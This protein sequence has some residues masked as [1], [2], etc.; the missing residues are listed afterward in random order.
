MLLPALSWKGKRRVRKSSTKTQTSHSLELEELEE[1]SRCAL[2]ASS[3]QWAASKPEF[4][5][6]FR[7]ASMVLVVLLV[8]WK[9]KGENKRK[10]AQTV[11]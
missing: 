5:G 11:R 10:L 7:R 2:V 4:F 1:L 9:T 6:L 3:R 8:D